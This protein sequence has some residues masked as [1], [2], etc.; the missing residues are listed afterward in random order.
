MFRKLQSIN[1]KRRK[2]LEF[3]GYKSIKG[4]RK[5]YPVFDS[6]EESYWYILGLYNDFY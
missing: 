1:K 6:N 3:L 5:D 4:F 2:L